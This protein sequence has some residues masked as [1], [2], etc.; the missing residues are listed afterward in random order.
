MALNFNVDLS[1]NKQ[2]LKNLVQVSTKNNKNK[3]ALGSEYGPHISK[4]IP[5]LNLEKKKDRTALSTKE[6]G[7]ISELLGVNHATVYELQTEYESL[8]EMAK[9]GENTNLQVLGGQNV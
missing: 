2:S 3:K 7:D 6:L 9:G 4:N 8:K 5:H 1:D